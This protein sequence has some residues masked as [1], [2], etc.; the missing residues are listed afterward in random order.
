MLPR[1]NVID[2]SQGLTVE[3]MKMDSFPGR[4]DVGFKR[5]LEIKHDFKVLGPSSARML[6]WTEM[7]MTAC[8]AGL[9]DRSRVWCAI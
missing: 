9:G 6:P 1:G 2:G 5:K 8:R 4:S 7:V 3:R